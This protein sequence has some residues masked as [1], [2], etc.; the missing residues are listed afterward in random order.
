M[1]IEH[2]TQQIIRIKPVFG[3]SWLVYA[4]VSYPGLP[5]MPQPFTFFSKR[6]AAAF[7]KTH[8]AQCA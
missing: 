2:A 4:M 7:C 1:K 3:Q 8:R 6:D 5:A